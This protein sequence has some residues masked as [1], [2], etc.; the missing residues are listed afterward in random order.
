MTVVAGNRVQLVPYNQFAWWNK[1]QF[2]PQ[3]AAAPFFMGQTVTSRL[4]QFTA[5]KMNALE[6]PSSSHADD[7][8]IDVRS[9][10]VRPGSELDM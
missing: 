1:Y 6:L 5:Q 2:N 8:A 9:V 10:R 4:D 3:W 7:A